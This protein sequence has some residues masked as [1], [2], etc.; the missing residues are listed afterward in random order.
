MRYLVYFLVLAN[1]AYFGWFQ[2]SPEQKP[3]DLLPVSV[4]P[5]I[6]RLLLLSERAVAEPPGDS[7]EV[8]VAVKKLAE[9]VEQL[10]AVAVQ[11]EIKH[12]TEQANANGAVSQDL[13]TESESV[14]VASEPVCHTVGPLLDTGDVTSIS[15]KLSQLGFQSNM[16]G[17]KLRE[18]AGY[19][20]YMPAMP[21]SKARRIVADLDA[22]GMKDYFIG[23]NNHISLGIFS[24]EKKARKRLS[25][26]K[27]LGYDSELGQRYRSRAVYWLDV[28]EGELPLLGSQTWEEIQ[29][30]H[31]DIGLQQVS[32][33][34][35]DH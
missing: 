13:E 7:R 2:Y 3:A 28:E 14:S 30:M 34:S 9:P 21:R 31:T 22:Q 6:N 8:E 20:V 18:P 5:G 26:V 17:D 23:R 4:P 29:E 11:T 16:R 10:A 25:R 12:T 32:C 15:E 27:E 33:A 19:W 35:L 24:T 1:L